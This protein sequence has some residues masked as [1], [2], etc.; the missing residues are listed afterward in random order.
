MD[1]THSQT[2][3]ITNN[4]E[5]L[6]DMSIQSNDVFPT[7]ENNGFFD[8]DNAAMGVTSKETPPLPTSRSTGPMSDITS[9]SSTGTGVDPGFENFLAGLFKS[10]D[11]HSKPTEV[12]VAGISSEQ[13]QTAELV[14]EN[15][16][17]SL[18]RPVMEGSV[19]ATRTIDTPLYRSAKTKSVEAVPGDVSRSFASKEFFPHLD[20]TPQLKQQ[21]SSGYATSFTTKG[22]TASV[23]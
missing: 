15:Q 7:K 3:N 23:S 5:L 4:A 14:K 22:R 12:T 9:K 2:I 11:P 18:V 17:P 20:R 16:A 21:Q 19:S 13:T 10:S 6:T 8:A 1:M